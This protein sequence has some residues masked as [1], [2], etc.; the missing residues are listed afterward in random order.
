MPENPDPQLNGTAFLAGGGEMGQLTRAHNWSDT[1][2]G[3][4]GNWP[5]SLKTTLSIILNSKFPMFLFWGPNHICFYNDA[6]RPSLGQKGKHPSMLGSKGETS[7]TEIWPDIKPLIDQVLAGGEA[8]WSEDQLLPIYRNGHLEDVYWTFSY[9]PVSDETGKPAGVFVTCTETTAKIFMVGQLKQNNGHLRMAIDAEKQA[10]RKVKEN[11]RNLRSIILQAPVA[12]AIFRGDGYTVEIANP[13]ALE[14]WGQTLADVVNK[15]I[16]DAM[17]ELRIQG[18]KELLDNVYQTGEPF[19]ATELPVQMLRNGQLET[20]YINFVYEPLFDLEGQ[21]NGLIT[22]GTEVT[23]QVLTRKAI[24]ES[25]AS[26]QAINEEMTASNEELQSTNEELSETQNYLRQMVNDLAASESRFR[27]LVQGAPV[28][29]G[30]LSSRRLLIE[31]ANGKIL[32]LWGKPADIV[33]KPLA[34]ALPELEG[35]SFLQLLDDVFTSG[36]PYYGNEERAYLVHDGELKELYFNYIY[37]PLSD[38]GNATNTIMIVAV[39]VTEQVNSKRE[40]QRAEEMLRFSIEA[41]NAATWYL[42]AETREFIASPRLK[43]L[44]GFAPD[45]DITYADVVAQIPDGYHDLINAA[46]QHAVATG[47]RY[48]MEHPIVGYDGKKRWVRGTGRLYPAVGN[49]KSHFSGLVIDITEQ[50]QDELRKNDFIGMVSHELKTPLT[51]L[52]A[53]VQVLNSKLKNNEDTFIAGALDKA[54]IQVKKMGAMINGFL[55]ISR[56]ESG[57][58]LIIKQKFS[59]DQLVREMIEEARL[60][61]ASH[62]IALCPC[63]PIEVYADKDKI[64][65]VISNLLSN[66]VKY[67]PKGKHIDVYCEK[68]DGYVQVSVKDEGMGVKPQDL[69]KLFDRYYRVESKHTAHISGFGIGLYLS[70][71]IIHRH[72]GEIWVKSE[73]GQGST[74]HF[75]LPLKFEEGD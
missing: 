34:V 15:P 27:F 69:D 6:Y 28:A 18:I 1:E 7:W 51:S 60:T 72:K 40:L 68:T 14:L 50:K 56:L 57:K 42:D 20:A 32:E 2:L 37:Q 59:I 26:L 33:G 62:E 3:H 65:S 17:P 13:R 8:S 45:A 54:N 30:V 29:I 5:Q 49:R 71:E 63:T 73:S 70:A 21:I 58:I 39:D 38:S 11:E 12:I 25:E 16:L 46:V 66:A 43:E 36:K 64:G 41:A 10:Q 44:F 53:I 9:S 31:S 47:E 61:T 35:Q 52:T 75:T 23:G 55:N 24:E 19:V 67:S 48:N 22:I 4:P 74:F